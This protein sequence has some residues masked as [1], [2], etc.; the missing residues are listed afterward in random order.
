VL[1]AS[2]SALALSL[3]WLLAALITGGTAWTPAFLASASAW[4][5]LFLK[6][7]RKPW[8][9]HPAAFC[10]LSALA[11][12][13][14]TFRWH[15]GDDITNSLFPIEVLK[16]H[17]LQMNDVISPWLD[18][19]SHDFIVDVGPHRLSFHPIF[20]GILAIPFYI[21]PVLFK[22]P[23][24]ET[25]LHNMSKL[26]AS[27][28][29]TLSVI[30]FYRAAAARASK[31]WALATT[32]IYA[33]GTFSFSISSQALF[34][35]G[36]TQLGAALIFWGLATNKDWSGFIA[37]LGCGVALAA[38]GDSVFF[39]V[40]A[41][42]YV[43]WRKPKTLFR[44]ILGAAGPIA[45][46]GSYWLYYTGK[47]AEPGTANQ[48]SGFGPFQTEAF[49][50]LLA[51]PTRGLIFFCPAAFFGLAA[52]FSKEKDERA[53]GVCFILACLGYW[54]FV[55]HF[56]AWT[57]GMTFGP[58]YFAMLATVLLLLSA[59]VED[60]VRRK[61]L[62][63]VWAAA[64]AFSIVT[65]A[66]GAYLTWPGSFNLGIQEATAWQFS[67]HPL[68]NTL[69]PD[70]ALGKLPLFARVVVLAG[71]LFFARALAK[72]LRRVVY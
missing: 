2:Q 57:A 8:E 32:L 13:L 38:R 25:F 14:S 21:I 11:A 69:R 39:A 41:G 19:K 46:I 66:L 35:H 56:R 4:L 7:N 23:I 64:G 24:T 1:R 6:S 29:V 5:L 20:T 67:L 45:L 55:S 43:L 53:L 18:G 63:A 71:L 26:S 68:L 51:S 15:G 42:L 65:H 36:A 37:G 70:G 34:Q 54:F 12:Y 44:F 27:C 59:G 62:L 40:A 58:R 9:K 10:A 3:L 49:F 16:Y 22:A 31:G 47:F 33:F 72:T 48:L 30:V 52:A 28:L 60:W 50:A 61:H 17:T